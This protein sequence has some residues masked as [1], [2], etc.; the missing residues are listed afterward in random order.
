VKPKLLRKSLALAA[1]LCCCATARADV[2]VFTDVGAFFAATKKV[3]IDSYDDLTPM[4]QYDG[5]NRVVGDYSY[6]VKGS[7]SVLYGAG[8]ATDPWLST[9]FQTDSI[10]FSNFTGGVTAFAGNFFGSDVF[11]HLDPHTS[12]TL[13]ADDGTTLKYQLNQTMDNTFLGFVSTSPLVSVTL[14]NDGSAVYWPTANNVVLGQSVMAVPEPGNYA[15]LLAGLTV[16]G[17]AARRRR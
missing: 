8:S 9:N 4:A 7:T 17:W 14:M 13:V 3:A 1:L 5:L 16:M 12:V 11:G 6:S 15:M 10:I 2:T